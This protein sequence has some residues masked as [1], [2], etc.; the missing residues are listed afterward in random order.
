MEYPKERIY[1]MIIPCIISMNTIGF[2]IM[3]GVHTTYIPLKKRIIIYENR[4]VNRY[5]NVFIK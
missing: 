3:L 4:S 1:Q 5:N 2:S